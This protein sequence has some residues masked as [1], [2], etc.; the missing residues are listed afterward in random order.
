MFA[1]IKIIYLPGLAAVLAL[2][3]ASCTEVPVDTAQI[4]NQKVVKEYESN[5]IAK[6]GQPAP[7]QSWD[8]SGRIVIE[9]STPG[10]LTIV[11]FDE[12]KCP[13][14]DNESAMTRV[15][16]S[17]ANPIYGTEYDI[18]GNPIVW[19]LNR[20]TTINELDFIKANEP[21]LEVLNWTTDMN[22][23]VYDLWPW[24]SHGF[25][26]QD[27]LCPDGI[28]IY[29]LGFHY[30]DKDEWEEVTD[31]TGTHM[32]LVS[33]GDEYWCM[34]PYGGY[35]ETYGEDL[36][37]AGN[38]Y[39]MRF[40]ASCFEDNEEIQDLFFFA[41]YDDGEEL[42]SET[43][44]CYN[45]GTEF[46]GDEETDYGSGRIIC[47]NCGTLNEQVSFYA[48]REK[49]ELKSY[50]E[51]VT[52]LG[53]LY[54][55]FDC[56]HDGDYTDLICLVE[57]VATKRY[58]IEDLGALDDFDFND[59]V[60]DV[61]YSSYTGQQNAF[62]R[63]M[64]GTL[65]FT[66][67]I[68]N[69]T[70]TKSAN[71]FD[72]ATVYNAD[73]DM[74]GGYEAVLAQFEVDGWVPDQNNISIT[75]K[76]KAG[77]MSGDDVEAFTTSSHFPIVGSVPKIIAINPQQAFRSPKDGTSIVYWMPERYSFPSRFFY[78]EDGE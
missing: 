47:P 68:G 4:M 42:T 38:R 53:G 71:N 72:A 22:H 9:T 45:C 36:Y 60:V 29:S 54:W 1:K 51:C 70:W 2:G 58:M 39:G 56:N 34:G 74:E 41:A 44:K 5:F 76:Q 49:F 19:A 46:T 17:A 75:V 66:L 13:N 40:D 15:I 8:F 50:K 59:I 25:E 12:S 6:Y 55:L 21:T 16:S 30:R 27:E 43:E 20:V 67:T 18:Y 32:F 73:G 33:S 77:D 31:D 61:A 26:G 64:G 7:D 63:A 78:V 65:D 11:P 57:P 62:V 37:Y 3:F 52:P 69:T 24:Y 23:G 35:A 14:A 48:F 28:A 10:G